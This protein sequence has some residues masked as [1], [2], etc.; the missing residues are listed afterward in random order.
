MPPLTVDPTALDGAGASLVDIGKDI[1]LTMST[2]SGTLSGCA[3]MCGNDPVGAAIGQRYDSSAAAVV[4]AI[5]AAR[6]GLV[7]LGDGVR[8]SAHN[9]SLADAQS[10]VSGRTQPLPVPAASGKIA[11]SPPPSSVGAGDAAPAGFGWVAKYI[12]M[13]WPNGDSVRLRAAAAAWTVAGTQLM[14]TETAAAG[15]LGI[16]GAQQIPEAEAMG[17][18]FQESITGAV[19]VMQQCT[20]MAAQLTAYAAKI[21]AVHAAIIDLLSRICD[22]MTGFKEVWDV[23]TGEDE[24]EIKQIADDIKMVVDNFQAE[25]SALATE[26]SAAM[27]AAENVASAMTKYANKEWNQFLHGTD[28]GRYVDTQLRF[29]KGVLAQAGGLIKDNWKYGPLRAMTQPERWFEDWKNTVTGMAPLV[30]LGGDGAPG[31]GESWK[32]VGK[33]VSHWDLWSKDPAEAAGR[34][35]FDIGTLFAPGGGVGAAGKATHGAAEAAEAAGRAAPRAADAAGR[36]AGDVAKG[37]EAAVPRVSGVHPPEVPAGAGKPSVAADGELTKPVAPAAAEPRTAP[38]TSPAPHGPTE[39]APGGADGPKMPGGPG[40][41]AVDVAASAA[42]RQAG[43]NQLADAPASAPATGSAG[44]GGG[45]ASDAMSS[46]AGG[47][48]DR[49]PAAVGAHGA[50]GAADG[51]GHGPHPRVGDGGGG[52]HGGSGD[53]DHLPH[54]GNDAHG[55]DI[56][57]LPDEAARLPAPVEKVEG[58]DYG[59]SPQSAFESLQDPA[60]ELARLREGG[61]PERLLGG[62]DPLAGRTIDE[63]QREFTFVDKDGNLR[64]D[65]EHQAPNNGFAGAAAV[66]DRIPAG[67]ELDRFGSMEGSFMA[68]SDSPLSTRGMPPGVATE[69]NTIVGTG[70]PVPDDMPWEVRH[71]PVKEAFG[72]PGGAPQWVVVNK[73]DGTPIPVEMLILK[74]IVRL[75]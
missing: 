47:T 72:Q 66:T 23:L 65:W 25:T 29:D 20:S 9:Y 26:M 53:S 27:A 43:A 22:P 50:A 67:L 62:Y 1:G 17:R 15:P 3:S 30:G 34:T 75:Q 38:G 7:N 14:V 68:E 35:A 19:Q 40:S 57:G 46:A 32:Q 52:L 74:R 70:R 48:G 33:E 41:S 60:R 21:D 44:S 58:Q 8:V 54:G 61:I 28:V 45:H 69:Y 71:G 6:N 39:R 64:W 49:V 56:E 13:I 11:A 4:Q 12:G 2:L 16:V 55:G 10:D 42:E 36:A 51:T 18:A 37:A 5:A 24:D 31:V 59:L 73:F 63:F